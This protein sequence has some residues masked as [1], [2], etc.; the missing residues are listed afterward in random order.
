MA[1]E[2]QVRFQRGWARV[3]GLMYWLVL[4]A[5]IAGTVVHSRIIARSLELAGSFFTVFLALGLYYALRPVQAALARTALALRLVESAF[6]VLSILVAFAGINARLGTTGAGVDLIRLAE[7]ADATDFSAFAFTIGSTI[8][9]SLFVRSGYIPRGL[10]WWGLFASVAAMGAC[11]THLAHPAFPAMTIY[12]WIPALLA[13]TSTG[14]W[15]LV[16]SVKVGS[17]KVGSV[18]V[19]SVK[20]APIEE[21]V[22][23]AAELR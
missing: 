3:A 10:A 22:P 12:P 19:G 21:R 13:E 1:S 5:D 20:V 18:K 4:V 23:A 9:F 16:K 2:R 6:G 7:W 14:L 11:L 17:V 15:L 8:F